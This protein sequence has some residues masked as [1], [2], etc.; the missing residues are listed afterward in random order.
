M[1]LFRSHRAAAQA[2]NRTIG[3]FYTVMAIWT[4]VF[5]A[6]VAGHYLFGWW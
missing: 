2:T 1:A 3:R 4:L 6:A 5:A